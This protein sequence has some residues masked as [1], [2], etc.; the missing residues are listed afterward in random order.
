[1]LSNI[2]AD[3]H[4]LLT[5]YILNDQA[6]MTVITQFSYEY[7]AFHRLREKYEAG[8]TKGRKSGLSNNL[9]SIKK[10]VE[11]LLAELIDL[12]VPPMM[13]SQTCLKKAEH[14]N[15]GA[16]GTSKSLNI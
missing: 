15:L 4:K 16:D 13:F 14:E 7:E 6:F 1:M 2:G 11:D 3:P 10:S 8:K 5:E 12:K 9:A